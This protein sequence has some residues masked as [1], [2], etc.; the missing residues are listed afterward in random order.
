MGGLLSE[1]S[2]TNNVAGLSSLSP[3]SPFQAKFSGELW[4]VRDM[5][6]ISPSRNFQGRMNKT[7]II[8]T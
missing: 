2:K 7:N 5:G 4:D 6:M 1:R 3:R 8:A